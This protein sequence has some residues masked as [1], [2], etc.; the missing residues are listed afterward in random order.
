[1]KNLL[2]SLIIVLY[3]IFTTGCNNY[4]VK[5][6]D[7]NK[8][9]VHKNPEKAYPLY[10]R[11]YNLAFKNSINLYNSI[12]DSTTL[13][14]RNNVKEF[15]EKASQ[16]VIE[17]E[18]I[19]KI[20]YMVLNN[21]P[22]DTSIRNEY[23]RATEKIIYWTF[24]LRKANTQLEILIN[25]KKVPKM[26]MEVK[27]DSIFRNIINMT[28]EK[29]NKFTLSNI[30]VDNGAAYN[31]EANTSIGPPIIALISVFSSSNVLLSQ[32]SRLG[33]PFDT[34]IYNFVDSLSLIEKS[35]ML[36]I[37]KGKMLNNFNP[38]IQTFEGILVSLYE[39]HSTYENTIATYTISDID[40]PQVND[41]NNSVTKYNFEV[42]IK[43][44][45]SALNYVLKI[46]V[47]FR[48]NSDF[49]IFESKSYQYTIDSKS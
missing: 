4:F 43:N 31:E 3:L 29:F 48:R 6:L 28:S 49:L 30:E 15:R 25:D 5:C 35:A 7:G 22:C 44:L 17:S 8:V 41:L 27:A 47:L 24:E 32:N 39:K 18:N 45:D 13:E 19:H 14:L 46:R 2:L 21:H 20:Y 10:A 12:F 38:N 34:N 23:L 16:N 40:F 11:D 42:S 33:K 1:M 26:Q 9:L 36:R 37:L